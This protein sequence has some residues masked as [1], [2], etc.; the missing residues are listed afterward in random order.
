MIHSMVDSY[1]FQFPR[2]FPSALC[3]QYVQCKKDSAYY[4]LPYINGYSTKREGH[5]RWTDADSDR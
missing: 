1:H 5:Q 2:L 4:K 3:N